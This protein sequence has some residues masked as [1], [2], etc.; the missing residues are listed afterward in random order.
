MKNDESLMDAEFVYFEWLDPGPSFKQNGARHKNAA[1]ERP[2][3]MLVDCM[4]Q[5][6]GCQD[7]PRLWEACDTLLE[8]GRRSGDPMELAKI[9]I[10][11]AIFELKHGRNSTARELLDDA[12]SRSVSHEHFNAVAHWLEGIAQARSPERIWKAVTSWDSALKIFTALS[13]KP[14]QG[15]GIDWYTARSKE[16][17]VFIDQQVRRPEKTPPT[18]EAQTAQSAQPVQ[19]EKPAEPVQPVQP[20]QPVQP[21]QPPKE[22]PPAYPSGVKTAAG[23]LRLIPIS[24][25]APASPFSPPRENVN[26]WIEVEEVWIDNQP[27]KVES[28]NSSDKLVNSPAGQQAYAHMVVGK[29]MNAVPLLPGDYVLINTTKEPASGDIV[30]AEKAQDD[31][32]GEELITLK[33]LLKRGSRLIL[34]YESRESEFMDKTID[35]SKVKFVIHGVAVARFVP[36]QPSA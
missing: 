15:D 25:N 27:Y 5:A 1:L 11:C 10:I 30:L 14:E 2:M 22:G 26:A 34:R 20:E 36:N 17:D 28:L 3:Q 19:T 9:E 35:S 23:Y 33:R 7:M 32:S 29:S 21:G 16:M 18:S 4:R 31:G 8:Q 6:E 12:I 24:Q 13:K